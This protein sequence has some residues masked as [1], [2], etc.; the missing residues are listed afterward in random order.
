MIL[1]VDDDPSVLAS[2][3]LLLKQAGFASHTSSGPADAVAWLSAHS[4]QLVL[5]DMN[6]TRQTTG[7]TTS[8]DTAT[9]VNQSQTQTAINTGSVTETATN[10]GN[11]ITGWK[12]LA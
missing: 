1:I 10:T 3:S 7:T 9:T 2:L 8:T 12:Q 5:Q 6:F 4:C 11:S